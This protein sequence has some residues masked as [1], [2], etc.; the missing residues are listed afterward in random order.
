MGLVARCAELSNCTSMTATARTLYFLVNPRSGGGQGTALA[1]LLREICGKDCVF[2]LGDADLRQVMSLSAKNEVAWVACGGDGT[3]SA[4]ADCMVGASVSVPVAIIPLGTGNDLARSLGWTGGSLTNEHVRAIVEQ[5][6]QAPIRQLDR[7]RLT[8]PG[9]DRLCL[10]YCSIGGDAAVA[11]QFHQTRLR[12]PHVLRGSLINK[13][14]YAV[15]GA[16]Q[17]AIPLRTMV[18]FEGGISVP[19]WAHA[20]VFSNI[21][22]YAGGVQLAADC[23]RDDGLLEVVALGHGLSLGLVTA[24][25]RRPRLVNHVS[26]LTFTLTAPIP[27]QVDGEPF[28]AAMGTYQLRSIGQIPILVANGAR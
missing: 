20:M 7:W 10:N 12:H 5:L 11:L 13:G 1:A 18:R 23:K 27:M 22:S 25:L 21:D 3:A 26:S 17:R 28:L 4:L 14:M 8:G 9:I 16:R 2:M 6:E 15:L 19:Q 24:R